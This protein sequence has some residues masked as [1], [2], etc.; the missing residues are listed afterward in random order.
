MFFCDFTTNHEEL[1]IIERIRK[2]DVGF[3]QCDERLKTVMMKCLG[4]EKARPRLAEVKHV[5]R[6]LLRERYESDTKRKNLPETSLSQK[7]NA[8]EK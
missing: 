6:Q 3:I 2:V 8:L 7:E 4:E 5:V 1:S